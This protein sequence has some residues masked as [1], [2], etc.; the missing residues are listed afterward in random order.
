MLAIDSSEGKGFLSSLQILLDS[1]NSIAA[2]LNVI[3]KYI[4]FYL[5]SFLHI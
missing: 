2:K 4:C 5:L 1:Q 3:M